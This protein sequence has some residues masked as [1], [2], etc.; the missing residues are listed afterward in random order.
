LVVEK[1]LKGRG[2]AT[3]VEFT[4]LLPEMPTG[5]AAIVRGQFGVFFL[6]KNEAGYEILSPYYPF[7]VAAPGA[8]KRAGTLI[9]Q[10]TR[11]L[12][13]VLAP[14]ESPPEIRRRA[15]SALDTV[16]TPLA[17]AVLK[18][19]AQ[20]HDSD[21]RVQA[22]VAL[23]ARGDIDLLEAGASIMLSSGQD[24]DQNLVNQLAHA[25]G[26][27]VKDPKATPVLVRLLRAPKAN[28]RRG[29]ASALRNIGG[30]EAIAPLSVAL[31][32][33]DDEVVWTAIMGLA[34]ITGDLDH[35]PG[36]Q[37]EFKGKQKENY[38]RYWRNWAKARK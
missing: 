7:V 20:R 8:P 19:V 27:G 4:F 28:V 34:E 37:E 11:E 30:N 18:H 3:R 23:L 24:T 9:D 29:A 2:A 13:H 33:S 17:G 21:I 14:S 36:A 12:E 1:M 16:R 25:V 35:G 6:R 5:Y 22:I 26:L 15:V 31:E 38:V 10:V 32:D